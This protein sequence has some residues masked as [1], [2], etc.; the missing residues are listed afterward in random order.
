MVLDLESAGA[1]VPG[2]YSKKPTEDFM[3]TKKVRVLRAFYHDKEIQP[4][5]KEFVIPLVKATEYK[6]A[7]KIEILPDPPP[8]E[9]KTEEVKVESVEPEKIETS[10]PEPET[11]HS[12]RR[13]R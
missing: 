12:G 3:E 13:R 2:K 7:N 1:L 10:Q 11:S 8:V 5:G 4:V 9:K 6:A